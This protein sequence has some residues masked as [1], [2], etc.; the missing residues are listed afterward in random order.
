MANKRIDVGVGKQATESKDAP[1]PRRRE[2]GFGIVAT[3]EDRQRLIEARKIVVL[4]EIERG[5]HLTKLHFGAHRVKHDAG[6][7]RLLDRGLEV[8]ADDDTARHLAEAKH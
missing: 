3:L 4:S 2:I 5:K 1:A 7:A 8:I 6:H